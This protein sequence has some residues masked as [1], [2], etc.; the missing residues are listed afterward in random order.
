MMTGCG[1]P[2]IGRLPILTCY[3]LRIVPCSWLIHL[4]TSRLPHQSR[5]DLGSPPYICIFHSTVKYIRRGLHLLVTTWDLVHYSLNVGMKSIDIH[6]HCF[7]K[8]SLTTDLLSRIHR[9]RSFQSRMEEYQFYYICF[10]M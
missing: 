4:W 2:Y 6:F 7:V 10:G 5:H 8:N 3:T 9:S 1:C